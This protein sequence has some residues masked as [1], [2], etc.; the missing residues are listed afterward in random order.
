MSAEELSGL[1]RSWA[2][3]GY[4]NEGAGREDLF[5]KVRE[6]CGVFGV[7][8]IPDAAALTYYGR[9]RCS[10]AARRAAASARSSRSGRSNRSGRIAAW[11]S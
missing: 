5:D 6:E 10:T 8:G 4:Y 3:G 7:F 1:I 9:T 11:A 2:D